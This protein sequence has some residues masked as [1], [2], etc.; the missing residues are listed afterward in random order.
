MQNLTCEVLIP[1]SEHLKPKSLM[2]LPALSMNFATSVQTEKRQ[3]FFWLSL[4]QAV[5]NMS[6]M[7]TLSKPPLQQ[8]PSQL[9]M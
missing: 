4:S 8:F 9:D 6:T 3:R 5:V 7:T 1:V 2:L